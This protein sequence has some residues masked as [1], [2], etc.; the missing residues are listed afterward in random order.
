LIFILLDQAEKKRDFDLALHIGRVH[1]KKKSPVEDVYDS[2]FIRTYIALAKTFKPTI[3]AKLHKE[4]VNRYIEK[5]K[6]QSD[7]SKEGENYT[8]TRSLLA[9]VRLCMARV[10]FINKVGETEIFERSKLL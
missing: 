4:L 1:Q 6:E 10:I 8:T 9:L 5:R 2:E 7:I 3:S